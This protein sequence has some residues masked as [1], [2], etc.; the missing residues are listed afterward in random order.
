MIHQLKTESQFFE[1]SADGKKNFEVRK[2]DRDF[3]VGDLLAL[4]EVEWNE[5]TKV[6]EYTGRCSMVLVTYVLDDPR[7]SPP[8]YVV[9]STLPCEIKK[10]ENNLRTPVYR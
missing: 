8:G 7:Y 6:L 5:K 2:N 3:K 4:N 9:L 10:K 1:A